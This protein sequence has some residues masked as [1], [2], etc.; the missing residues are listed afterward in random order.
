MNR[1]NFIRRL[2]IAAAFLAACVP[3]F[4]ESTPPNA[5]APSPQEEIRDLKQIIRQLTERLEKLE[6]LVP[7]PLAAPEPAP[8]A[9]AKPASETPAAKP[10]PT[11]SL[12]TSILGEKTEKPPELENI[13]DE[14][15]WF[16]GPKDKLKMGVITQVDGRFF[17]GGSPGD[18]TFQ[19]RRAR[20]YATGVIAEKW[21]YMLMPRW[22]RGNAGLHFAWIESQHLPWL[23]LRVGQFKEPYSL[24]GVNSDLYLDFDERSLWVANLVHIED[25]GAMAYGKLLDDH[26]EYGIGAFNGRGKD[27][28]DTN[29]EK[30]MVGQLTFVPFR[31]FDIEELRNLYIS[32]SGSVSKMENDLAGT[33]YQTGAQTPFLTY[34]GGVNPQG[35]KLRSSAELEWFVGP[36]SVRGGVHHAKLANLHLGPATGDF[37]IDGYTV[38]SSWLLTGEKKP[39]NKPVRP[40]ADF[41]PGKDGWGAFELAARYDV[42]DA[43]RSLISQGFATGTHGA[44]AVTVGFNWYFNKNICMKLDY[45]N[46]SFAGPI[47]FNGESVVDENTL[48]GRVQLEF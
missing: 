25:I 3:V 8:P 14:G 37:N 20:L 34:A 13:Y 40:K 18:D 12:L 46:V 21:G 11:G 47:L 15:F 31:T 29:D 48:T 27:R 33:S 24:E 35:D 16:V 23:R 17:L 1:L 36:V 32:F 7:A 44:D 39:R 5:A 41:D 22:D 45:Q 28:S 4:P 42:F 2:A 6:K 9:A 38:S 19:I 30:E 10:K 26:V 43:D